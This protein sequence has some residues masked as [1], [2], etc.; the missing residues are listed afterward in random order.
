MSPRPRDLI[1]RTALPYLPIGWGQLSAEL[2]RPS[3]SPR[4]FP[5]LWVLKT[6]HPKTA[7]INLPLQI[8]RGYAEREDEG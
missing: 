5:A 8:L 2:S 6:P 7:I 1:S 3:I 4:C